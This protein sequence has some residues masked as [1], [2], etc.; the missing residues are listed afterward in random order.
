MISDKMRAQMYRDH[1]QRL[2]YVRCRV[3]SGSVRLSS[4]ISANCANSDSIRSL[5]NGNRSESNPNFLHGQQYTTLEKE[6]IHRHRLSTKSII[7][8]HQNMVKSKSSATNERL[9]KQRCIPM[10]YPSI[11]LKLKALRPVGRVLIQLYTEAS[12]QVVLE[13]IRLARNNSADSLFITRVFPS[14]WLEGELKLPPESHTHRKHE[15]DTRSLNHTNHGGIISYS[16]E[17]ISGIE[18]DRLS[19]AISFRPLPAANSKRIAFGRIVGGLK[20]LYELQ[21]YGTKNG[22]PT[23]K[24]CISK[25]GLFSKTLPS[26]RY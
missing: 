17:N 5:K 19:F 2:R 22:K 23:R 12:P 26:R 8:A 21:D 1:R 7:A 9:N 13:F 14:L 10:T 16:R 18:S 20:Y 24:I 11:A 15:F 4:R 3:N 25:C 6:N